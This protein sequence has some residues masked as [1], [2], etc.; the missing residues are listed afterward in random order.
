MILHV[1]ISL[2]YM[3]DVR[4]ASYLAADMHPSRIVGGES[5][6]GEG[7][8]VGQS[9]LFQCLCKHICSRTQVCLQRTV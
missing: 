5:F 6:G 7:A 1:V 4:I 3:T 8:L 2:T 9:Q